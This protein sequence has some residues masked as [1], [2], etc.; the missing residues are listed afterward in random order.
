MASCAYC[1]TTILFGGKRRGDLRF[2]NAECEQRGVLASVANQVPQQ[3]V[4]RYLAQVHRGN[5]PICN[6]NGPIDVH[7]SY[8]AWSALVLT[9][10]SSR[11]SVCCQSCGKKRKIVDAIF[12]VL[13]GW[14]GLPWGLLITPLQVGRNIIGFFRSPDPATPSPALEKILRLQLAASA[15]QGEQHKEPGA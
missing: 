8:R 15:M 2:C 6:G 1:N 5:C 10:W 9:S 13:L 14:W 12:S 3:V 4:D 7:T 11:P